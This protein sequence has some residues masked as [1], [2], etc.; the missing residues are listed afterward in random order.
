MEIRGAV[1]FVQLR[2]EGITMN[3]E[4]RR[5]ISGPIYSGKFNK[6]SEFKNVIRTTQHSKTVTKDMSCFIKKIDL[7]FCYFVDIEAYDQGMVCCHE[8]MPLARSW[9]NMN[10]V[11]EN[12]LEAWMEFKHQNICDFYTTVLCEGLR[13]YLVS[14]HGIGTIKE[15]IKLNSS[16]AWGSEPRVGG[17]GT[18]TAFLKAGETKNMLQGLYKALLYIH[19]LDY[20][21]S[22]L[23]YENVVISKTNGNTVAKLSG[24]P[25]VG[26]LNPVD[27]RGQAINDDTKKLQLQV[28]DVKQLGKV[29]VPLLMATN[30]DI[31]AMVQLYRNMQSSNNNID[32]ELVNKEAA[33]FSDVQVEEATRVA[34]WLQFQAENPYYY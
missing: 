34:K 27:E 19:D 23:N 2:E 30:S 11:M 33:N 9:D 15:F 24:F 7:E 1:D 3:A 6:D 26:R 32:P 29:F 17:I 28:H 20:F 13:F 16:H 10:K 22:V 25:F 14:E 18:V 21:V 31:D 4:V 5:E 8:Q 12:E